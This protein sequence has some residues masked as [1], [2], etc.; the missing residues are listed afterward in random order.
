M[1]AGAPVAPKV[2][3]WPT[4]LAVASSI[5]ALGED[6]SNRKPGSTQDTAFH[7]HPPIFLI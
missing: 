6:L 3:R 4:E 1:E 2:K 5:H 7:Y